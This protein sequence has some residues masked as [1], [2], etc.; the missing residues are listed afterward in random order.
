[1]HDNPTGEATKKLGRMLSL[2]AMY[3]QE[4]AMVGMGEWRDEVGRS[5][6][7][8]VSLERAVR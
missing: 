4:R 3:F 8:S 7:T 5:K 6:F 1:M 2:S